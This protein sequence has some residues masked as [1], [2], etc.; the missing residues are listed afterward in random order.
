[1]GS[2]DRPDARELRRL[3]PNDVVTRA[4]EAVFLGTSAPQNTQAQAGQTYGG[5]GQYG[6]PFALVP[7]YGG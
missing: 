1:M 4:E 2:G 6:N 5:Y 7:N 3:A